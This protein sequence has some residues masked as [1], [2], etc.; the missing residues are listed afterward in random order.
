MSGGRAPEG[1]EQS[2]WLL[3]PWKP[4]PTRGSFDCSGRLLALSVCRWGW[5]GGRVSLDSGLKSRKFNLKPSKQ[6]WGCS[7]RLLGC[8]WISGLRTLAGQQGLWS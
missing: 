2:E 3:V 1:S 8:S 7:G 4:F 5:G 6:N